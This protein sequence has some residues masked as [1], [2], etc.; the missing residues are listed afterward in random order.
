MRF[1]SFEAIRQ[2]GDD[3]CWMLN[4]IE[5]ITTKYFHFMFQIQWIFGRFIL[6]FKTFRISKGNIIMYLSAYW[7]LQSFTGDNNWS[8]Y[9]RKTHCA[10]IVKKNNSKTYIVV[11][12]SFEFVSKFKINTNPFLLKSTIQIWKVAKRVLLNVCFCET[13]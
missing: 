10:R 7:R 8:W 3:I 9:Y 13:L 12:P 4:I 11:N 1:V 6:Q 5:S 2:I